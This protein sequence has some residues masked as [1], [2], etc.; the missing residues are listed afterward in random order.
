MYA[1]NTLFLTRNCPNKGGNYRIL[2][3][4]GIIVLSF[5]I[6]RY[7]VRQAE[8]KDEI[9][10]EKIEASKSEKIEDRISKADEI[11]TEYVK[12][13]DWCDKSYHIFGTA[14]IFEIDENNYTVVNT[15]D[16]YNFVGTEITRT[17]RA[18]IDFHSGYGKVKDFSYE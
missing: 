9:E 10:Q 2:I 11:L 8:F 18:C 4:I 17:F 16:T 12:S 7:N 15:V 1:K 6:N 5:F 14:R 3:I 13:Q